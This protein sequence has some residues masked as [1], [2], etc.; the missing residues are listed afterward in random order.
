MNIKNVPACRAS[1][2]RASLFGRVDTKVLFILDFD[3]YYFPICAGPPAIPHPMVRIL[4]GYSEND[5]QD[6]ARIIGLFEA[7]Q[8]SELCCSRFNQMP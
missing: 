6:N 4:D 8:K 2:R 7:E 1:G 3:G 5:A